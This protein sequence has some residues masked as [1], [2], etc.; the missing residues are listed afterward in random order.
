MIT[1]KRARFIPISETGPR[2]DTHVWLKIVEYLSLADIKTLR[3][4]S[5]GLR[6]IG[7][8]HMGAKY[9]FYFH[10]VGEFME[11]F[12][13]YIR[14]YIRKLWVSSSLRVSLDELPNTLTHLTIITWGDQVIT[15]FPLGLTYLRIIDHGGDV[16]ISIQDLP[17]TLRCLDINVHCEQSL[18]QLPHTLIKLRVGHHYRYTLE[19]VPES[20]FIERY[21]NAY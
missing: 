4:V 5:Q 16:Y 10:Y 8:V 18:E 7:Q 12:M 1:S 15:N 9:T 2:F 19:K 21:I 20:I 17:T 13:D 11:S 3:L 14:P 6:H